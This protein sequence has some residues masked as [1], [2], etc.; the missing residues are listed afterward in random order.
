M[1]DNLIEFG[2]DPTYGEQLYIF[3]ISDRNFRRLNL[4]LI[5]LM[6]SHCIFLRFQTKISDDYDDSFIPQDNKKIKI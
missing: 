4:D 2:L 6:E 3:L 5:Q 1:I